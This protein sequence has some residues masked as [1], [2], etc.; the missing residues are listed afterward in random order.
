MRLGKGMAMKTLGVHTRSVGHAIAKQTPTV[1]RMVCRVDAMLTRTMVKAGLASSRG[2]VLVKRMVSGG[3]ETVIVIA[4]GISAM[5]MANMTHDGMVLVVEGS[6]SPGNENM[7]ML[8]L[9]SRN[10]G[11]PAGL[12]AGE[13]ESAEMIGSG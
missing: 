4:T 11:T 5:R 7:L 13:T 12:A 2:R 9:A 3:S 6:T 8:E 1:R 10:P